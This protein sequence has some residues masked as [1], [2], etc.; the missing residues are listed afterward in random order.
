LP[1]DAIKKKLTGKQL[2]YNEIF[3]IMDE[4]ANQRLGPV[5]TAYFAAAGFREGF[6]DEEL[7]HLTRAMVCNGTLFCI[8][9]ESLLINIQQAGAGTRRR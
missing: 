5:L 1:I 2:S 8:L 6:S 7:Y 3:A 4:I 9:K